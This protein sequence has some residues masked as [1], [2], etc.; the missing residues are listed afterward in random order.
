[1]L[2]KRSDHVGKRFLRFVSSAYH[3]FSCLRKK[4][5]PFVNAM[6]MIVIMNYR[7]IAI[8]FLQIL[9]N[10]THLR[11]SVTVSC[12]INFSVNIVCN[13]KVINSRKETKISLL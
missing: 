8:F 9:I 11:C 10:K 2:S 3:S 5:N 1:M 4:T 7:S 13:S 6:I 12:R